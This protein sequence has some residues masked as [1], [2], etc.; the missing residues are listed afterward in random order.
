MNSHGLKSIRVV[1]FK[2]MRDLLRDR[3]T[4]ISMV[5]VPMILMPLLIVGVASMATKVVGQARQETAK[6]MVVGGKDSPETVAALDKVRGIKIVPTVADYTNMI[7]EKK[8]GAAV[9]IPTGFDAALAGGSNTTSVHIYTYQGDLKSGFAA[10]S[11]EQFFRQRK[12]EVVNR[13][14]EERHVSQT[15]LEPFHVTRANVVSEKKVTG[16]LLGMILPYLVIVMC[17]TGAIYPAVDLTAGEKERGT[18]ETLLC[19]PAPRTHLVLGKVLVV[20]TV[21]VVTA[22]LSIISNGTALLMIKGMTPGAKAS[23]PGLAIDPSSMAWICVMMIP[24]AVFISALMVAA[25]LFARSSK[26]ANT[27]LQPMLFLAILPAAAG[28]LPGVEM[29][30]RLGLIPVF[31]VSF[32]AKE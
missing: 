8:I 12:E 1:Y 27:Y 11:L 15:L 17:I 13:R 16:S 10:E 2:E 20:M 18:M 3:R 28:G 19:S 26:E 21:S 9:E 7:S 30:Y 23:T 4:L 25:G 24:M 6:V 32:M 5:V 29:N 22:L 14:L 31:N